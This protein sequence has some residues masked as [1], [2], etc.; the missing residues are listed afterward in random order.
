M[1]RVTITFDL[2]DEAAE[3]RLTMDAAEYQA[4]LIDIDRL[5]RDAIKYCDPSEMERAFAQKVRALIPDTIHE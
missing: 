2:P 1:P 4:A 5:C 3:F